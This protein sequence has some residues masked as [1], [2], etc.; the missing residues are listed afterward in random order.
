MGFNASLNVGDFIRR[1]SLVATKN[2]AL[3]LDQVL[4]D[5]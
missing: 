1:P 2:L 4:T 5:H 3:I